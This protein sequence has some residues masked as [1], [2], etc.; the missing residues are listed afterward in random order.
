[1]IVPPVN[2]IYKFSAQPYLLWKHSVMTRGRNVR[3][4]EPEWSDLLAKAKRLGTYGSEII[5]LK[6]RDVLAEPDEVTAQWLAERNGRDR[7][8][9]QDHQKLRLQVP[10][11]ERPVP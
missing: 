5:R 10:S 2:C 6:I 11:T 9:R 4:D 3:V 7:P 1:M 8:P